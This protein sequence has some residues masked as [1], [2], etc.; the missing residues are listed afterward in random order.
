MVDRGGDAMKL[1]PIKAGWA[2]R[3]EG[4]AVHAPTKEEAERKYLEAERQHREI[5]E[6]SLKSATPTPPMRPISS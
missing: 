5:E 1:E 3:G 6:R 2:A 4:W